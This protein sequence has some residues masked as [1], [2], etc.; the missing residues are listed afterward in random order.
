MS[1]V[2]KDVVDRIDESREPVE[3][4]AV[5]VPDYLREWLREITVASEASTGRKFSTENVLEDMI[6][7]YI[8]SMPLQRQCEYPIKELPKDHRAGLNQVGVTIWT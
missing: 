3:A 5:L 6:E 8:S 1:I 4:Y 2:I 7:R